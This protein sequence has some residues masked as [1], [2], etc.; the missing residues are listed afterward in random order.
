MVGY[1]RL[2]QN[3]ASI[4]PNTWFRQVL[5]SGVRWRPGRFGKSKV[6]QAFENF[7]VIDDGM[8]LGVMKFRITHDA[9]R[10]ENNKHPTTWIHWEELQAYLQ[11]NSREGWFVEVE[12]NRQAT[13]PFELRFVKARPSWR[14]GG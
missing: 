2:T 9:M 11:A 3:R 5:F 14:P 4:D 8:D 6:E 13:P 12:R 7:R 1:L 10:P